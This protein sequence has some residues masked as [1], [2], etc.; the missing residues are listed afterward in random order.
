MSVSIDQVWA[1]AERIAPHTH[2]TPVLRSR[3]LEQMV[4]AEIHFK[5]E[6]L[7]RVGAVRGAGRRGA[8]R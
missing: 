6:N 8:G 4:G 2:R 5:A 7:Q 1:A 3:S